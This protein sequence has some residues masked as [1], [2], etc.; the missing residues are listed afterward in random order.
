MHVRYKV[1][2]LR[3]GSRGLSRRNQNMQHKESQH[4]EVNILNEKFLYLKQLV[5]SYS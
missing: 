3:R 2:L 5:Y 4:A 1:A